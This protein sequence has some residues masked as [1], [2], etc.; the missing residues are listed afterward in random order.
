MPKI[1]RQQQKSLHL[2]FRQL[3]DELNQQGMTVKKTL[4]EDFDVMWSETLFKEI[5]WRKLQK[6][7]FGTKSTRELDSEQINKIFDVINK[8]F[9]ENLKIHI[10]FPSIETLEEYQKELEKKVDNN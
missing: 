10:P 5:I 8:H 1:T 3:S 4:R 2:L 9:G 7:M 6:A